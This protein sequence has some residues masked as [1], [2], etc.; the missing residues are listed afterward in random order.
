MEH[1]NSTT[2]AA[3]VPGQCR[4]AEGGPV[5]A[6]QC[7]PAA[8]VPAVPHSYHTLPDVRV[9]GHEGLATTQGTNSTARRLSIKLPEVQTRQVNRKS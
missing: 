3:V 4:H 1:F 8:L 7:S 9:W 5:S 2:A 6:E